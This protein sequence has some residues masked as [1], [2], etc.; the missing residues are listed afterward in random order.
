[1]PKKDRF[2][3]CKTLRGD[4]RA[5][6]RPKSV[7]VNCNHRR[8]YQRSSEDGEWSKSNVLV[9]KIAENFNVS[10]NSILGS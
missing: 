7:A 3:R 2:Q 8:K 9:R 4:K 6:G 10:N 1:M 5:T